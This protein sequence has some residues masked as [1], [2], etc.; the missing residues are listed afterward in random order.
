M[1]SLLRW[2][3]ENSTTDH[4]SS[5]EPPPGPRKDLDP[6]IIEAI[7]GKSDAVLMKD[8]LAV[9]IDETQCIEDR[10]TALDDLEMLVEQIDNANNLTP[11][12]MYPKILSL[13]SQTSPDL[14]RMGALWILG[15]AVQNNPKA[16]ADFLRYDPL[17]VILSI[18][19]PTSSKWHIATASQTR[20]KAAYALSAS[21]KHNALAVVRLS[22]VDGWEIL[23]ESLQ[24]SDI[25]IRRK[26][27][28]L[29]NALLLPTLSSATSSAAPD[30]TPPGPT[31]HSSPPNT[32]AISS[33]GH[34]EDSAATS[35]LPPGLVDPTSTSSLAL[36]ALRTH[37]IVSALVESLTSPVPHGPDADSEID[38]DY[39]E[40][41]ARAM[42]TFLEVGG[43]LTSSEKSQLLVSMT[44]GK[45]TQD[46]WDLDDNE[47][48]LLKRKVSD[49]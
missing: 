39:M 32:E 28:F 46:A 1:E 41:A 19:S 15:T 25:T 49:V 21:L 10:V 13:L 30:I 38:E 27:A 45:A 7:L 44:G 4:E 31:I 37:G 33:T 42:F 11:L 24:D 16:Q 36:E 29:L 35:S 48:D 20:S 8:A 22:E 5:T 23:R 43:E 9:G 26:I 6:G 40:K 3:I 47:W 2:G 34:T 14:L 18:L 17:P 12:Q